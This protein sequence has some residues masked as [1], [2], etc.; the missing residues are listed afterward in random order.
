MIEMQE[1][2]NFIRET[3]SQ[4]PRFAACA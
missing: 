3:P 4:L 1:V 2:A